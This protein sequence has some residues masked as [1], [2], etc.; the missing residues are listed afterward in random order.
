MRCGISGEMQESPGAPWQEVSLGREELLLTALR[1]S[2][3][4][5]RG[6]EKL[7]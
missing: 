7:E 4:S 1:W 6:D 5:S 3:W 2:V